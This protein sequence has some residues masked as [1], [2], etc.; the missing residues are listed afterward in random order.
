MSTSQRLLAG[1][2]CVFLTASLVACGS[3]GNGGGSV[4]TVKGQPI[5]HAELDAKL[6]DSPASRSVLQ[7][8]VTNVLIDKY[9]QEHSITVS[10]AEI[11]KVENQY[12]AQYP[13]G[14]W[15]DLLKSRGLTEQ[16]VRDLIRRQIVLDKAV[17]ANIHVTDKQIADYFSKNHAQYDQPAT[18]H[19][20]H[21]LV[22]DLKTAD[23][24]EADLKAGKD[25]A[26][27]AK[28]YSVDPGS[29]E[30]GGDLGWFRKGQMVP[31]FENYAFN[32]PIGKISAPIKSPFGYH[33]IQV[34]ERKP[35][36]LATLASA[37][38]QIQQ[39]L[40]QQQESPLIPNFLQQL[41]ANGQITVDDPKFA[42][43]FPS[44]AAAAPAAS[45][46]APAPT[47]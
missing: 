34:L 23:K 25:F 18:A 6:E 32:G 1:I 33:V 4:V 44:P 36:K 27:E 45:A 37:H 15:D 31:A 47:K 19:A 11:D 24:V 8:L 39:T 43:V 10:D 9:A 38:D 12:K 42:S 41:Q 3:G 26:A 30:K 13:N 28:Q 17:G 20:R 29:K 16:D 35:A 22:P 2:A 7:Q 46:A 21:I 40:R 5:T 14:G